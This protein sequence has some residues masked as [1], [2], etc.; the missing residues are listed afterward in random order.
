MQEFDHVCRV[1]LC[2]FSSREKKSFW[3]AFFFCPF[4]VLCECVIGIVQPNSRRLSAFRK[5]FSV[6]VCTHYWMWV[7]LACGY[8]IASAK[9][10]NC[11]RLLCSKAIF[12]VS[13]H[14]C[15]LT[16]WHLHWNTIWLRTT[17]CL[18]GVELVYD[19]IASRLTKYSIRTFALFSFCFT[20]PRMLNKN[21]VIARF[22]LPFFSP[23]SSLSLCTPCHPRHHERSPLVASK[24]SSS[25][26]RNM[27]KRWKRV[28]S[29][30]C[31]ISS[32][33][34]LL[35]D[36]SYAGWP[37]I[38]WLL[39]QRSQRNSAHSGQQL[40]GTHQQGHGYG[41]FLTKER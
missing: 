14:Y 13:R 18:L 12:R 28:N 36:S 32:T 10:R 22:S 26:N 6:K 34:S 41:W 17:R 38:V 11:G 24:K 20:S 8:D 4:T 31:Y 7:L 27:L 5:C 30:T 19:A 25:W 23:P 33:Y 37:D 40:C 1:G 3:H 35:F 39:E 21:V 9:L 15:C 2:H 16:A 29:F